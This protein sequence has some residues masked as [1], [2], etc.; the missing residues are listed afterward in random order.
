[1]V[2]NKIPS[3]AGLGGVRHPVW[4]LAGVL[5]RWMARFRLY[6]LVMLVKI[7]LP[8]FPQS[9]DEAKHL[10]HRSCLFRGVSIV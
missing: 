1:V 5:D 8:A 10:R 9:C 4:R 2:E 7:P 3:R 6:F